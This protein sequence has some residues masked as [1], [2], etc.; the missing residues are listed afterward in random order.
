M[1]MLLYQQVVLICQC[2]E[3]F[4][5]LSIFYHYD[6]RYINSAL[7]DRVYLQLT[8]LK[9]QLN[10]SYKKTSWPNISAF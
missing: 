1:T 9:Y 3:E 2:D 4:L 5:E 7:I 6:S 8:L 10:I